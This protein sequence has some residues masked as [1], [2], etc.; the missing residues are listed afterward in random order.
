MPLFKKQALSPGRF[1]VNRLDGTKSEETFTKDRIA[2]IHANTK[3]VHEAGWLIPAPW[4]HDGSKPI[5]KEELA[6]GKNNA[7]FVLRN[8]LDADTG[9]LTS[10]VEVP[11]EED[12]KR[13]GTTVKEVSPYLIENW[14]DPTGRVFEGEIM[15]HLAF[16]TNPIQPG[17][18]NFIDY[19]PAQAGELAIAMSMYLGPL[20]DDKTP[21]T[22]NKP[23]SQPGGTDTQALTSCLEALRERGIDLPED[24][25]PENLV[26]R[27]VIACRAISGAETED[28]ALQNDATQQPQ[29]IAMGQNM[30]AEARLAKLAE[31]T[32]TNM[33]ATF[34]SRI[35]ALVAKGLNPKVAKE[36]L[37]PL[38]EGFQLSQA[39]DGTITSG[40][41]E[42]RLSTLEAAYGATQGTKFTE[43]QA[44]VALGQYDNAEGAEHHGHPGPWDEGRELTDDERKAA[45]KAQLETSGFAH[46]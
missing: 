8:E 46:A 32:N 7:G 15:A 20:D 27:I 24:T 9:N 14:V 31:L 40:E 28:D 25:T 45:I 2:K 41:L 1:N 26:E 35:A 11:L 39:E 30:T 23:K 4:K 12:A 19:K 36:T 3:K 22:T 21:P 17:Q 42:L 16:I 29:P 13:V 18:D 6:N 34:K 37:E 33:K 38:C 10:V 44:G 43:G 5:T